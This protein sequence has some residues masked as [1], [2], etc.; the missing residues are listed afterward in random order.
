MKFLTGNRIEAFESITV[1]S[2]DTSK[3]YLYDRNFT[4]KWQSVGSTDA[5]TETI[6]IVWGAAKTFDRICLIGHNLKSFTIQY[7][8]GAAY[9][10]F[11][12]PISETVNAL[13]NSFFSFNAV[14]ATQLKLS[15]TVAQTTDAQ[16]YIAQFLA[17]Q[18]YFDIPDEYMPDSE[19]PIAYYKEYEHEL[20]DGGSL[21]VVEATAS[22][23]RNTFSFSGLPQTYRDYI[24]TLK[25]AHQ[26]FWFL[27][28]DDVYADQYLCNMLNPQ[29]KKVGYWVPATGERCYSGSF[30]VKEA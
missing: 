5:T 25:D 7:W 14:S 12:T 26:S 24:F 15:A 19:N 28:F 16:K 9:V 6:E 18:E 21:I 2:G 23:Y 10:D 27:P 11:S 8:N 1:L 3:Q 13:T 4:T 30:E 22:K 29:F 20:V 17:Y